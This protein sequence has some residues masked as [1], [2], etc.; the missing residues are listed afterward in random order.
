MTEEKD[1]NKDRQENAIFAFTVVTIIFLPLST[2]AGILGMNTNDVRNMNVDQ[3]VFWA[4]AIPLLLVI[5]FL[6]LLWT[7]EL[8]N[9]WK[10]FRDL[11]RPKIH[12]LTFELPADFSKRLLHDDRRFSKEGGYAARD[13]KYI[14]PSRY[15]E[16]EPPVPRPRR[17]RSDFYA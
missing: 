15:D 9:I 4:T 7:N 3:W 6:C 14:Y 10:G 11:W 1:K 2:V 13:N 12:P 17:T 5:L 8:G 16:H